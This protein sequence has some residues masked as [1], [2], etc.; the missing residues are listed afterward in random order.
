MADLV[1]WEADGWEAD[2]WAGHLVITSP[3]GDC[4]NVALRDTAT[5]RDITLSQF[6]ASV[7]T[8]GVRKACEVFW[9]LRAQ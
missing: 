6:R 2:W 7:K 9:K 5:G 8:H 4:A 3:D 1:T